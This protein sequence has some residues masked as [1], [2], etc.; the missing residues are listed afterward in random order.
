[1]DAEIWNYVLVKIYPGGIRTRNGSWTLRQIRGFIHRA[2]RFILIACYLCFEF[3]SINIFIFFCLFILFSVNNIIQFIHSDFPSYICLYMRLYFFLLLRS[4]FTH[5]YSYIYKTG[6]STVHLANC[7]SCV[8]FNPLPVPVCLS[9]RIL[10]VRLRN[11]DSFTI[12]CNLSVL[13]FVFSHTGRSR[14]CR[15]QYTCSF[16]TIL[17]AYRLS[18]GLP[19]SGG[20]CRGSFRVC[21]V[22]CFHR[23]FFMFFVLL[24]SI[25]PRHM[26]HVEGHTFFV[27]PSFIMFVRRLTF[28]LHRRS[29]GFVS[30]PSF[31][32]KLAFVISFR[33]PSLTIESIKS[34]IIIFM[35]TATFLCREIMIYF[36]YECKFNYTSIHLLTQQT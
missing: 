29:C 4:K 20:K 26:K 23:A 27:L 22:C 2:I 1:M 15:I 25:Y 28:F 14:F 21:F 36:I 6:F 33:E 35:T 32:Q 18:D 8:T 3:V 16:G 31:Y 9:N 5:F 12:E 17:G 10:P 34:N 24:L 30:Y 19:M 13:E 11:C 7:I